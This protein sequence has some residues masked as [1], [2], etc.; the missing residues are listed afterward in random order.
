MSQPD[1]QKEILGT[2]FG[3][4]V[5][6]GILLAVCYPLG[7]IGQRDFGFV[8]GGFLLGVALTRHLWKRDE[9]KWFEERDALL[10]RLAELNRHL[11]AARDKDES[12]A[13][14]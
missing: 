11:L 10:A 14:H 13:L 6:V 7:L 12:D 1:T 2:F 8:L 5:T 9:A 3:Y 4:V